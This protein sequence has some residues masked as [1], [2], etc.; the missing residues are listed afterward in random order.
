MIKKI[1]IV[2]LLALIVI[3][4]F[5]PAKNIHT[6]PEATANDIGKVY[7]IPADV[8]GILKTS[9]YDC[10]SNN[11]VYPWY[12]S[13][14]PTAWWLS[15]H[16]NDGKK[17][18]NFNEFASYSPKKQAHKLEEVVEE[19]K[20]DAMPLSSYTF[21]HGD[22]KLSDAQKLAITQWADSLR[23]QISVT[24]I[25]PEAPKESEKNK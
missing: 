7:A 5:R 17:H 25:V 16:V 24:R 8:Q 18:L 21:I 1:L 23:R 10:H 11:T 13:I 3:Q 14:Q 19:I 2:L 20:K 22:A 9:C 6:G 12:A 15:D 4:F